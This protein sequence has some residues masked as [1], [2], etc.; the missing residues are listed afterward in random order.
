MRKNQCVNPGNSKGQSAFFPPKDHT[1]S[2]AKILD[3]T[4]V[5][6]ITEIEFTIRTGTK[7]IEMHEY[8]EMHPRKLRITMKLY[9]S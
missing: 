8:G 7:I 2:L 6:E 4:E 1:T 5:A 9:R 3:W